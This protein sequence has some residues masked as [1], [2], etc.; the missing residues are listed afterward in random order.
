MKVIYFTPRPFSLAFGGTE[1]QLLETRS[2]LE[3]LGLT[4]EFIDYMDRDQI[5]D[6]TVVHLFGSDYVFAQIAKLLSG[7]QI[8]YVVSSIFYPTGLSRLLY[9]VSA[10]LPYSASALRKSVL[11][12]ANKVLPNS[13]SESA[14]LERLFG[15]PTSAMKVIP[16][17]VR[18]D[19]L[20]QDP[21]GFRRKY[22]PG[23]PKEE[24]FVLSVGRIEKR[25]N[26]LSLLRAAAR[27]KV[28][29]VFIGTPV[30][31]PGEGNYVARFQEELERYPGYIKHIPFLPN[32]SNDLADAYAAAHA[33]ALVS[34]METPGLANLE[35][36]LNGANLVVGKSPPVW[37]YLSN[38]AIF[39]DQDN[40]NQIG[41]AIE[42]AISQSRDIHNQSTYIKE[43]YSWN[44]VAR[45][46]MD[47][48]REVLKK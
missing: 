42:R 31:L 7:R 6:S 36:G 22:L 45:L 15:L 8:P 4:V 24:Q 35:A 28:P 27:L 48:Y 46:L 11:R 39:V 29:L 33:H 12:E 10:F 41:N 3:A 2:A 34:W 20:G 16:N 26:S 19:F 5:T 44:K 21:D 38:H 13:Q 18:Q 47:I 30:A 37:E 9:S 32:G 23:L 14:L 43:N 40:P 17:A 1:V 25:K